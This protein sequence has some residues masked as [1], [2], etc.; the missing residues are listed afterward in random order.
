MTDVSVHGPAVKLH[1]HKK[2]TARREMSLTCHPLSFLPQSQELQMQALAISKMYAREVKI[3]EGMEALIKT[4][5]GMC[6]YMSV[7]EQGWRAGNF[8][9]SAFV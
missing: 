4:M 3:R 6:I 7:R 2:K 9:C 5:W 1:N 8:P